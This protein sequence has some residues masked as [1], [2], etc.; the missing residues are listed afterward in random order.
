M[1]NSD[2]NPKEV[3]DTTTDDQQETLFCHVTCKYDRKEK[4]KNKKLDMIRCSICYK[5][6]H[7]ECVWLTKDAKPII[8]PCPECCDIY[9]DIIKIREKVDDT[10]S[11]LRDSLLRANRDLDKANRFLDETHA[12]CNRLREDSRTLTSQLENMRKRVSDLEQDIQRKTWQT[13]RNKRS[14]LIGDSIIRDVDEEKLLK[15]SVKSLPGAK[16]NDI[17]QHFLDDSTCDEPMSHIYVCVGTNDCSDE[18][19]DANA[20][21]SAYKTMVQEMTKHVSEPSHVTISSVVPRKDSIEHQTRV[22]ALNNALSVMARSVGV[23]FIDHDKN[24]KLADGDINDGYLLPNDLLHLT[25][26][27]TNKLVKNLKLPL[28]QD[29]TDVTRPRRRSKPKQKTGSPPKSNKTDQV[30]TVIEDAD[31]DDQPWQPARRRSS[32]WTRSNWN[33]GHDYLHNHGHSHNRGHSHNHDQYDG[34]SIKRHHDSSIPCDNKRRCQYCAEHN[35]STAEC[36]F[37]KPALCRQCGNHGHKQKFCVEFT[38]R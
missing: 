10:I 26:Q 37:R 23:T 17:A 6:Y 8:W 38:R 22:E 4:H 9:Q 36:G 25:K 35:H 33:N 34:N 12:E 24:F 16:V 3:V 29:C 21:T 31:S 5:W 20:V 28:K 7:N 14:L 13:F 15:T 1:S 11:I 32:R 27:G 30:P 18:T 19:M 2:T